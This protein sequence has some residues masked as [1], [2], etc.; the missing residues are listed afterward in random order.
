M[1]PSCAASHRD[2]L[3][4]SIEWED[5]GSDDVRRANTP[6]VRSAA[7]ALTNFETG[8]RWK[9]VSRLMSLG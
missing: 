1:D 3:L 4:K 8:H 9:S 5:P 2:A 7:A 6:R